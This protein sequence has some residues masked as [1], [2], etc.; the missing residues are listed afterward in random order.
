[1][2]PQGFAFRTSS[3]Q[4]QIG[5][6]TKK[7]YQ[8]R[9]GPHSHGNWAMVLFFFGGPHRTI[10]RHGPHSPA[11]WV[12]LPRC[13]WLRNCLIN[14]AGSQR[15]G[16][17]CMAPFRCKSCQ[18]VSTPAQVHPLSTVRTPAK[19]NQSRSGVPAQHCMH[20]CQKVSTPA[21]LR[22]LSTA[23]TPAKW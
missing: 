15:K 20:A 4:D 12:D 8:P 1:M 9:H 11:R 14:P 13:L 19:W 7:W 2:R 23:C 18:V 3:S 5:C 17:N 6:P 21:Q 10:G 16:C 22:L